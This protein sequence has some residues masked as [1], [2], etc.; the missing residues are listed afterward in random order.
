ME[1]KEDEMNKDTR[2]IRSMLSHGIRVKAAAVS[3]S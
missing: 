1:E 2:C 3:L